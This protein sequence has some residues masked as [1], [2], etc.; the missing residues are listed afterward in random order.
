MLYV[1]EPLPLPM[2]ELGLGTLKEV[3]FIF[4]NPAVVGSGSGGDPCTNFKL[5]SGFQHTWRHDIRVE[6]G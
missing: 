1:G 5:A 6:L 4:I 2:L 3:L